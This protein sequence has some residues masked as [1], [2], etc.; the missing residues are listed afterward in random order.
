MSDIQLAA[1]C[2][3][4]DGDPIVPV[5]A[6]SKKP[7]RRTGAGAD[8][9]RVARAEVETPEGLDDLLLPVDLPALQQTIIDDGEIVALIL[10]RCSRGCPESW[11]RTR[12]PRCGAPWSR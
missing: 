6:N 10:I 4:D 11:T 3:I 5:P 8:L 9:D 2:Y 1:Q 12:T 7:P